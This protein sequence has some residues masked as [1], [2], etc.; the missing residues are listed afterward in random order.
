MPCPSCKGRFSRTIDTRPSGS[1][2]RRRRL[3][4][5]CGYRYTT[6]EVRSHHQ[7]PPIG[8]QSEQVQR[9]ISEVT[10]AVNKLVKLL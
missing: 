8:N 5:T 2:T 4:V 1:Q 9:A 10:Q 6:Y 7:V 3:C